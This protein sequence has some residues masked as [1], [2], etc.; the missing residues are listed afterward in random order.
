MLRKIVA[1]FAITAALFLVAAAGKA[2]TDIECTGRI[3]AV[4][5]TITPEAVNVDVILSDPR[6]FCFS[7]RI[8]L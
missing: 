7:G 5:V 1:L 8:A 4:L 6:A 3:D 2:A